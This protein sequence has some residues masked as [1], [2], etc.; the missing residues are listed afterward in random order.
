MIRDVTALAEIR[1][2]WASPENPR[3]R[4]T[5]TQLPRSVSQKHPVVQRQN[6]TSQFSVRLL[7]KPQSR[8]TLARYGLWQKAMRCPEPQRSEGAGS[9]TPW[10]PGHACHG[11]RDDA[12]CVD[13]GSP[14]DT[15]GSICERLTALRRPF[16]H[17]IEGH[18]LFF[19]HTPLAGAE[20]HHLWLGGSRARAA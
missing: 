2:N 8:N 20:H 14:T 15:P 19:Y 6:P 3:Y 18:H 16:I 5:G 1:K 11:S 17:A 9:P 7:H 13:H 10:Q 12:R 4:E